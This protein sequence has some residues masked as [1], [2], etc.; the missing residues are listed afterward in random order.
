MS[1]NTVLLG[2][3]LQDRIDKTDNGVPGLS[4]LPV[5][6]D[7]FSQRTDK[8]TRVELVIMITPRVVRSNTEIDTVTRVIR[9]QSRIR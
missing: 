8:T 6:G 3:L 4:K 7:L 9:S 5:V 2:G 1:G